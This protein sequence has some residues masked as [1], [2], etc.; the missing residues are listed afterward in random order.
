MADKLKAGVLALVLIGF[1]VAVWRVPDLLNVDPADFSARGGRK[2]CP[3]AEL[4]L[5]PSN[6]YPCGIVGF[7]GGMG[8]LTAKVD[9]VH[10]VD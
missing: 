6:G 4:A 5:V 8:A 7:A 1:C 9:A 10:Q 3:N 2:N